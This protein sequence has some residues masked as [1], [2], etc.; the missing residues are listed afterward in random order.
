[1]S[2]RGYAV[3]RL[4]VHGDVETLTRRVSATAVGL[5]AGTLIAAGLLS[6][7]GS[8]SGSNGH[9]TNNSPYPHAFS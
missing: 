7:G 3:P 6:G 8:G 2:K 1:M 9:H 5:T 4:R